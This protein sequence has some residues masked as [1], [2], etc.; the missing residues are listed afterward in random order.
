MHLQKQTINI[1]IR[2]TLLERKKKKALIK[3][4]EISYKN[5]QFKLQFPN[6]QFYILG[7]FSSTSVISVSFLAKH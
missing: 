5:T 7:L 4:R 6:I 1:S 3:Q 2:I